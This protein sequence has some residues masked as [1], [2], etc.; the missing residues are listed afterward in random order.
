[1]ITG[2]VLAAGAGRRFG[3]PKAFARSDG[4]TW[5]ARA[6]ESLVGAGCG[7]VIVT[8]PELRDLEFSDAHPIVVA[9]SE[10]QSASLRAALDA[11]PGDAVAVMITLVDLPDV[12]AA[13]VGRVIERA[14]P[15]TPEVLARATY[16]GEPGHPVLIGRAHFD[17]L[18]QSLG[19]DRGARHYLTAH[20][21]Q[22]IE[23]A[24]LASGVD[25]DER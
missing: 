8:V 25:V 2:I 16:G 14:G 11:L 7:P 6:V 12:D 9:S 1:V 20:S 10:G 23:C 4:Q 24:D 13:V 18:R 17:A 22:A 19:G 3:G 15:V 21:T 5:V